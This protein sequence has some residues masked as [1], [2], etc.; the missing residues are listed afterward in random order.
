MIK[1]PFP[2]IVKHFFHVKKIPR[3]QANQKRR[4]VMITA[5]SSAKNLTAGMN[6]GL[7][8]PDGAG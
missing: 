2:L 5:P 3:S 6:A 1:P 7:Q 8:R 4:P